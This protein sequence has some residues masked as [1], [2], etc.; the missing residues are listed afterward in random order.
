M[1]GSL[2]DDDV[3][4]PRLPPSR[5][6]GRSQPLPAPAIATPLLDPLDFLGR[7]INET[8]YVPVLGNGDTRL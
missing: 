3:S 5:V 4:V 1:V 6:P 7:R 8:W 2:D